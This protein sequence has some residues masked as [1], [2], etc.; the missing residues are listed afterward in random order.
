MVILISLNVYQLLIPLKIQYIWRL[1]EMAYKEGNIIWRY[2]LV[3]VG[4]V[5]LEGEC[6]CGGRF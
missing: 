1:K 3:G 6:Q 2:V 4:V 5:L